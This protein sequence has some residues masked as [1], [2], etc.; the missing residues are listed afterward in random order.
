MEFLMDWQNITH[1]VKF[2]LFNFALLIVFHLIFYFEDILFFF[3]KF[4]G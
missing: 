1:K 3:I 4:I 2:I